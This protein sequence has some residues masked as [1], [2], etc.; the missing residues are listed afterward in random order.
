M[1]FQYLEESIVVLEMAN[2]KDSEAIQNKLKEFKKI[3][4]I[5]DYIQ[6]SD[7]EIRELSSKLQIQSNISDSKMIWIETGMKMLNENIKRKLK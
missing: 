6:I 2:R 1:K 3:K 4:S 7:Y 5:L